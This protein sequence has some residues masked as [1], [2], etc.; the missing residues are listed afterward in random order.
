VSGKLKQLFVRGET[1]LERS[2]AELDARRDADGRFRIS[3]FFCH[4]D[5]WQS[6][7]LRL[8]KSTDVVLMDLRSFAQNHAGCVFEIKELLD[9]VP[10]ERLVFVVD[11]TTD[12]RFLEQTVEECDRDLRSNSPNQGVSL[13]VLQMFELQSLDYREL[14]GLLRTLCAAVQL[15]H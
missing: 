3:D 2:L 11:R 7:L 8:V 10:L 4:A 5:T 12:M 6:V 14:Q 9:S 15:H 13:S 1:T